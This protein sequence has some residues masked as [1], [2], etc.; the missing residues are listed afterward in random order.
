MPVLWLCMSFSGT[1]GPSL[2]HGIIREKR[3]TPPRSP[4]FFGRSKPNFG[5]C[6]TPRGKTTRHKGDFLFPLGKAHA[7]GQPNYQVKLGQIYVTNGAVRPCHSRTRYCDWHV[8]GRLCWALWKVRR[9]SFSAISWRSTCDMPCTLLQGSLSNKTVFSLIY[10]CGKVFGLNR[11][12]S[13]KLFSQ[14]LLAVS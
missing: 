8:T 7:G 11:R 12:F 2:W 1:R 6:H 3:T 10:F 5:S 13:Q 4:S 14:H 9:L